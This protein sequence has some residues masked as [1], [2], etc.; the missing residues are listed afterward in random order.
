VCGPGI[1]AAGNNEVMGGSCGEHEGIQTKKGAGVWPAV[2]SS[3]LWAADGLSASTGLRFFQPWK[4]RRHQVVAQ[5]ATTAS[6]GPRLFRC[7]RLN[8][9]GCLDL[10]CLVLSEHHRAVACVR[11]EARVCAGAF[12]SGMRRRIV[13]GPGISVAGKDEVMGESCGEPEGV[14]TKKGAEVW[15][16]IVS[17]PGTSAAGNNEVM[18]GGGGELEG[19]QTK[20]GAGCGLRSYLPGC[21]LPLCFDRGTAFQPWKFSLILTTFYIYYLI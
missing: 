6:M 1:S 20:K 10:A 12:G 8:R 9:L 11:G 2:V 7:G 13:R 16:Q 15:H 21:G 14:Q 19:I 18:S 3:G 17:G 4:F 5:N